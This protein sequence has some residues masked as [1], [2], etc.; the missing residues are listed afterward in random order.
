[1]R[2]RPS[3]LVVE[4][5][6]DIVTMLRYNLEREGFAVRA[7]GDG[8][9]ALAMIARRSSRS[10]AILDWMLPSVSGLEVCRSLRRSPRDALRCRSSC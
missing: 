8:E 5:E 7:T 10:L 1:M 4:D 9:E 2:V 3:I 6:R